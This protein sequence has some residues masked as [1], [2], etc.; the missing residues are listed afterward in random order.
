MSGGQLQ[1]TGPSTEARPLPAW[2]DP[3]SVAAA[4]SL[5]RGHAL[6]LVGAPLWVIVV[7]L[8]TWALSRTGFESLGWLLCYVIALSWAAMNPGRMVAVLARSWPVLLLPLLALASTFWSVDPAQTFRAAFQ[9]AMTV[10]IAAVIAATVPPRSALFLLFGAGTLTVALSLL[11]AAIAFQPPVYE[12]NGAFVGIFPQKNVAG[13]AFM[14]TAAGLSASIL[15]RPWLLLLAAPFLALLLAMI[16]AAHSTSALLSFGMLAI[17][18]GL[19]WLGG[20]SATSRLVALLAVLGIA[21]VPLLAMATGVDLI[22]WG[23]NLVG[24]TRDLT[25]RTA[26]WSAGYDV[27]Q[28][29]PLLGTGFA[30]FWSNEHLFPIIEI[31]HGTVDDRLNGF[32][33]LIVEAAVTLGGIGVVA[34]TGMLT[35]T[36][37]RCVSWQIT[38]GSAEAHVWMGIVAIS[39]IVALQGVS[40]MRQHE[41]YQILI[42]MAAIYAGNA[43]PLRVRL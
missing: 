42:T 19:A 27:W 37:L 38:E 8:S 43:Q 3:V 20:R 16:L 40:V 5:P 39:I 41:I 36:V 17:P 26:I 9:F 23:L 13:S 12:P 25:G 28:R 32:H 7:L 34:L 14:L 33:N 29:Y 1:I 31:V 24:K 15:L 10:L 2:R 4:P 6:D 21:A 30:A 18:V 35:W 22:D 11:N